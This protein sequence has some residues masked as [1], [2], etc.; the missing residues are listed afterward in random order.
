MIPSMP[1]G[2]HSD[3]RLLAIF[4]G[5]QGVSFLSSFNRLP[6]SLFVFKNQNFVLWGVERF[7]T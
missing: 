2:F 5:S 4:M 6:V 1:V 7:P 3:L